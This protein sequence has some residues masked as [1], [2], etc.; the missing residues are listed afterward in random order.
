MEDPNKKSNINL[1]SS[2]SYQGS[3]RYTPVTDTHI[4]A[5][6][7][8]EA[9]EMAGGYGRFQCILLFLMILSMNSAGFIVYGASYYELDPPYVC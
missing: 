7:V 8:N 1:S 5:V 9:L 6:T 4:N 3:E 2:T